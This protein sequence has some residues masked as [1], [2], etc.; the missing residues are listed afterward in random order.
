[1]VFIAKDLQIGDNLAWVSTCGGV[2]QACVVPCAGY[3]Q[4]LIGRRGTLA[5]GLLFLL[6]GIILTALAKSFAYLIAG[7][8]IAG[9]GGGIS[10]LTAIAAI[11]ELVPMRSRG[12]YLGL[13]NM[14]TVIFTP[15]VLY[16]QE[17]SDHASW[18]WLFWISL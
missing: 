2:A 12:F 10:E 4:D 14:L 15:A 17:I 16:A 6:V 9:I 11:S 3:L 1:M 8:V 18:R 13:V 7:G 5:L